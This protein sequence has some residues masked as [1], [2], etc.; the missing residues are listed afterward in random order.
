MTH[1]E[2][3]DICQEVG[4]VAECNGPYTS[5]LAAMLADRS[6]DQLTVADLLHAIRVRTTR[7]N[8]LMDGLAVGSIPFPRG[9]KS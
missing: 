5:G 3:L 9:S 4:A 1:E 7:Y 8:H 2:L 6:A